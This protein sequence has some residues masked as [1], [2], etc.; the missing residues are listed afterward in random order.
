MGERVRLTMIVAAARNGV[1]GR[2]GQ[3]PW[4]M[5]SDLKNFK[6]L[7]LGKPVV[8]GRKTYQSIGR[9]LPGRANVVVT[10]GTFAAPAGVHVARTIEAAL[11]LARRLAEADGAGEVCVIGGGEIYRA[12]LAHADRVVLTRIAADLAG[13]VRFPDLDA[14]VWREVERRPLMIGTNDDYPADVIV[15]ERRA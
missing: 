9:P 14:T 8:M 1:I 4:R 12:A 13:D 10:R 15:Y 3:M 7:T 5:P 6:V 11:D 2:N